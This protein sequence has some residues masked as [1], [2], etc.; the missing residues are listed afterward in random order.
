M[1]ANSVKNIAAMPLS[2]LA[3]LTTACVVSWLLTPPLQ[4]LAIRL[5]AVSRPG[6]RNVHTQLVPRLGGPALFVAF[7]TPLFVLFQLGSFSHWHTSVSDAMQLHTQQGLGLFFGGLV[8]LVVGGIDDVRALGAKRKLLAQI[9]AAG[10]AYAGGFRLDV[11][12]FPVLGVVHLGA[13]AFPLTALWIVGIIN[14]INL[15]D[16]LDGLAAG[17]VFFVAFTNATVAYMQDAIFVCVI[18]VAV[19]GAV[20]GFLF[21]NF[22]PARVFMGDSGSYFLGF[23]LAVGSM[24]GPFQK[25]SAAV[26]L[27][28]PI[29]AMGIP[30]TD[31]L[32]AMVRRVLERRPIFSPDRGHIHHRLLDM[33]LTHRRAVLLIYTAQIVLAVS[34]IGLAI[35]RRWQVGLAILAISVVMFTV[36]R[37]AGMF[38]S[39]TQNRLQRLRYG[40]TE[41]I[42][43]LQA[44]LTAYALSVTA[45]R[46]EAEIWQLFTDAIA[47]AGF[48]RASLVSAAGERTA[49]FDAPHAQTPGARLSA[50]YALGPEASATTDVEFE[51]RSAHD[52]ASEASALLHFAVDLT[53]Q[54]LARLRRD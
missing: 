44:A 48:D 24:A 25:A 1:H 3:A 17:V 26:S 50:R 45:A 9:A 47:R 32:F 29:V 37:T 15:I 12:D 33:G 5:G 46:N 35:G 20:L 28:V 14:A 7:W 31:T 39:A 51:W 36:I 38:G 10:I 22:N 43:K 4:R 18:M 54:A 34:A 19:L 42:Q 2:Y 23:V 13:F 41:E 52:N 49:L 6:G 21:H 53:A 40:S 11:I 30:I 8:M 27:L 16:G